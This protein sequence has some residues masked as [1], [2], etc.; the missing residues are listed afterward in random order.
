MDEITTKWKHTCG[1]TLKELVA[2]T[3]PEQLFCDECGEV[4]G[5]T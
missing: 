1:G 5:T 2:S 3:E 4:V